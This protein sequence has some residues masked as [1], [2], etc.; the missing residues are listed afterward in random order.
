MK[1]SHTTAI[2]KATRLV[3]ISFLISLV[4]AMYNFYEVNSGLLTNEL[5]K[6]IP[7]KTSQRNVLALIYVQLTTHLT[8]TRA[9]NDVTSS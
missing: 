8:H 5:V 3:L 4:L 2:T 1:G 9:N 7:C 6:D